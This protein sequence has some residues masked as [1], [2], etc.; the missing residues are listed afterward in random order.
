MTTQNQLVTVKRNW[1]KKQI[2]LGKME[3]KCD[4]SLTDD[5]QFDNGNDFGKTGWMPARMSHPEYAEY[6]N[7]VGN[8]D[9]RC[10]NHDFVEGAMNFHDYEF[11]G[12]AGGAYKND[13]GT[14]HLYVHSNCSFTLRMKA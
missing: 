5:Y 3:A 6:I 4:L 8:R 14:I 10:I 9:T 7:Q 1:I 2:E 12:K 13:D 11:T